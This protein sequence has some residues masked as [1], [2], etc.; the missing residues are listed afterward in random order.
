[1][2]SINYN[3]GSKST[4]LKGNRKRFLATLTYYTC[5]SIYGGLAKYAFDVGSPEAS[6]IFLGLSLDYLGL[7]IYSSTAWLKIHYKRSDSNVNSS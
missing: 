7:G 5:A 2:R 1:V 4:H 6:A 3:N